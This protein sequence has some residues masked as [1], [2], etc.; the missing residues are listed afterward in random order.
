M[1]D[2]HHAEAVAIRKI[3]NRAGFRFYRWE[4]IG[5]DDMLLT[6]C[7]CNSVYTRGPHRGLPKYDGDAVQ[8]VVSGAEL[9]AERARYEA[10]TGKCSDCLG[11]AR[12]VASCGVSGTKY[13]PCAACKGSGKPPSADAVDPVGG[14]GQEG[15]RAPKDRA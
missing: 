5:E 15:P 12:T 6:G 14:S 8:A 4:C 1:N 13:R 3:G 9:A 7:V 2:A 10:Q 11:T